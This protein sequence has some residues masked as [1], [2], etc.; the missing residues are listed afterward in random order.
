[1]VKPY[2]IEHKKAADESDEDRDFV[3][4]YIKAINQSSESLTSFHG[5]RGE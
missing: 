2:I 1:M 3:D 5:A 4:A